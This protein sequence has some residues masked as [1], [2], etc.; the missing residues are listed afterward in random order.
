MKAYCLIRAQPWYR[1]EAFAAGLAAAGLEVKIGAPPPGERGAVLVIWNRYADNHELA[2]RV[3]RDGGRVWV[4]ENG[5]LGAGGSSSKF[6]VYPNGGQ[7]GHYYAIEETWHNGGGRWPAGGPERFARLGVTLKPWRTAGEHILVCPNR[8]FGVAGRIMP[9]DWPQ[10]VQAALGRVTKRPVRVR[11]H[12]GNDA[13][14][15]PLSADLA[16]AWAVVIW[17]SSAG[18]H[19]LVEGVP[20]FCQAPAWICK[21]A[22]FSDLA[23]IEQLGICGHHGRQAALEAMAW[24]QWT[25]EEIASG[26]PFRRLLESSAA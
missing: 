13:P 2:C 19:A 14:R 1:R 26:E 21:P 20:V 10:R 15:R 23:R 12:P 7:A 24:A 9:S 8:S 4:A 17:S 11:P 3:E 16:N 18:V 22:T 5:Y 6:D 25:V